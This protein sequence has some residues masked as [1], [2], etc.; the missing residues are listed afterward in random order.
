VR[1][2]TVQDANDSTA[3]AIERVTRDLLSERFTL[4][5][6]VRRYGPDAGSGMSNVL[7]G[8]QLGLLG[9]REVLAFVREHIEDFD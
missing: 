5:E 6:L 2:E 1:R 4:S 3:G 7:T 9:R 8:F